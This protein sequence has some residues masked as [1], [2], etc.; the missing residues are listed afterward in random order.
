MGLEYIDTKVKQNMNKYSY[1]DIGNK[2]H[3]TI[4]FIHGYGNTANM[5]LPLMEKLK[6]THR[7]IS[8]NL[9]FVVHPYHKYH[10]NSLVSYVQKF[11]TIKN[12]DNFSLV[13]FSLGG[14][15]ATRIA[16]SCYRQISHLYLLNVLPRLYTSNFE[17]IFFK[18]VKLPLSKNKLHKILYPIT[19]PT[20]KPLNPSRPTLFYN[21]D[22]D[23]LEEFNQLKM[24]KSIAL[25]KDDI[26]FRKKRASKI[27]PLVSADI[28]YFNSGGHATKPEYWKNI[29][30]LFN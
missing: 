17:R 2:S 9:P 10:L 13:G 18:A 19:R 8:L 22:I 6:E 24:E 23:L 12:I 27:V 25:F 15:V 4:L 26:L 7:C 5:F 16:S 20:K 28:S 30:T 11:I 14:L 29:E 1:I 21:I 3:P